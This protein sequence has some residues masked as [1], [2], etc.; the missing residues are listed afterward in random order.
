MHSVVSSI[1]QKVARTVPCAFGNCFSYN[2]VY[3]S[4]LN[5]TPVSAEEF[6]PGNFEKYSN[7]SALMEQARVDEHLA[8]IKKAKCFMHFSYEVTNK[9]LMEVNL[10]GVGYQLCDPEIASS[11]IRGW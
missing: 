6:I 2:E 9:E 3:F 5:G 4:T 10:K 1:C 7:N 11:L 8:F